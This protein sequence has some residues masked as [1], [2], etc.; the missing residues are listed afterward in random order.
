MRIF[1]KVDDMLMY[2]RYIE[3]MRRCLQHQW[4]N[5]PRLAEIVKILETLERE[6]E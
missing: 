1:S 2:E 6:V 5:R 4:N 3:L